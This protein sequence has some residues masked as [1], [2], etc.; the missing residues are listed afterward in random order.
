MITVETSFQFLNQDGNT[1]EKYEK[2]LSKMA[3]LKVKN[4]LKKKKHPE[5]KYSG[6]FAMKVGT[7]TRSAYKV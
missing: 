1:Y 5:H 2:I 7:I 4:C 6:T 3:R